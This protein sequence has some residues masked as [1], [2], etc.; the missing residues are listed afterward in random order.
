MQH[1]DVIYYLSPLFWIFFLVIK[2]Q[3]QQQQQQKLNKVSQSRQKYHLTIT[4]CFF[5]FPT[6]KYFFVCSGNKCLFTKALCNPPEGN[7]SVFGGI[8]SKHYAS[9]LSNKGL[10]LQVILFHKVLYQHT[11]LSI[12]RNCKTVSSQ[13]ENTSLHFVHDNRVYSH[14]LHI[15]GLF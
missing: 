6:L 3:N 14:N 7:F 11:L 2:K 13:S 10:A 1:H 4:K 12:E 9:P 5:I 15:K 8:R